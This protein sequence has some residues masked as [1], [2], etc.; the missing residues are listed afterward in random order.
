MVAIHF[1]DMT[2]TADFKIEREVV[3]DAQLSR[4]VPL[5]SQEV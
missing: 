4:A 2:T 3:I 5:T 1:T